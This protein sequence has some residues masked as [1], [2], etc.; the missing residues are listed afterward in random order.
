MELS[1]NNLQITAAYEPDPSIIV[2][3]NAHQWKR[4]VIDADGDVVFDPNAFDV[5]QIV[6]AR[7]PTGA[8]KYLMKW[9]RLP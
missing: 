8:R 6:G 2:S 7:G 1:P 9:G 3:C 5:E 4:L